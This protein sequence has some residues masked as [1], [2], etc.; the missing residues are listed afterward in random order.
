MSESLLAGIMGDEEEKPDVEAPA[1][2]AGAE[3]FAAAVAARLAGNDPE[4]ARETSEFL[5]DQSTLL[6]LQAKH[7]GEEHTARLH[8]LQGQAREV[9][10]RRLG[11]R[12]R[13]A[14]QIF[15]ALF[16]TVVG[17]GI[18]IMIHD[19]ITS[20]SVVVES[21]DAPPSLTNRGVTG[22]VVASNL[23]DALV[24]LQNATRTSAQKRSL[25]NAWTHDIQLDVPETGI[26]VGE[27]DRLLEARFGHDLHIN[28][29]LIQTASGGLTLTV[30]GDGVAPKSFEG[31][32]GDLQKLTVGA[33]EYVYSQSEPTLWVT[34]LSNT[35]RYTEAIDFARA[36]YAGAD[37]SDRPY[38]LNYWGNSLASI[39]GAA[40]ETLELYRAALRLKPDYWIAYNNV[41]NMLWGMGDEEGAWRV[42]GDLLVAAGGRPGRAPE[43][44][45]Q[46]W[47]VLTWNLGPWLVATMADADLHGGIGTGAIS[48]G[49]SLA[50]IHERLHDPTA[51]QIAIDTTKAG[52]GDATIVAITHFVR[53]RL[54]F[55][56]GD[57]DRARREMEAFSE[58]FAKPD[59]YNNFPGYNCWV[60]PV[61]ERAGHPDKADALLEHAGSFVDC[62][63]FRADV[64]DGR[65]DWPA[66]QKAYSS[67]VALAP[68]LPAAYYSWGVA[69]AAHGDL[70]SSLDKL[71]KA[72][73]RGP[74]WADPL[75]A[76]GDVFARQGKSKEAL[77][78]Y[79]EALRY[80]PNWAQLKLARATLKNTRG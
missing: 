24:Q 53:G 3:A 27:I 35:G 49:P 5:R 78:K 32:P 72:N 39:G 48:L 75:K 80:A 63:R 47:D 20:R 70:D 71:Q 54:A 41:M 8:Y 56:A 28:G 76:W 13:V 12:L 30:R 7:L 60:A 34:Y 17:A 31:A 77:A 68:D 65:G 37:K 40:T 36:A 9:D 33:A 69:L 42:G 61:E 51:A 50:D 21:F 23:L 15:V 29:E 59:V 11:L 55:D 6:K 22:K 43:E 52:E 1:G 79:D 45:Y 46:N 64:L 18:A 58:A 2:I 38:L 67:A 25:S 74:H 44:E 19:A 57:M 66:A 4:V 10:L 73:Q 26:S 14:F 62:Y 16:A